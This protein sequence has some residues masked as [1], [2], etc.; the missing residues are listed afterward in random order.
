MKRKG[1]RRKFVV[2][3]CVEVEVDQAVFDAVLTDEWRAQFYPFF[4]PADVAGNL[5]FCLV[6]G[7]S[8]SSLDGYADQD[9]NSASI[10]PIDIEDVRE[11]D[12]PGEDGTNPIR[13]HPDEPKPTPRAHPKKVA[14]DRRSKNR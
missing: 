10:G 11:I 14:N 6:Q 5:A 12:P 1:S 2:G 9:K 13:V 4:T 3:F 7:M 8:I